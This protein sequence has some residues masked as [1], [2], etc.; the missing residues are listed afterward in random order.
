MN[1]KKLCKQQKGFR[2]LKRVEKFSDV[3]TGA[4]IILFGFSFFPQIVSAV[5]PRVNTNCE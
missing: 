5:S 1:T 3:I 4:A 2:K